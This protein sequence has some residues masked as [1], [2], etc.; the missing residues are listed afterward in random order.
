MRYAFQ[1]QFFKVL[2]NPTRI[3]VLDALRDGEH[4]VSDLCE[5]LDT[6]QTTMS[7]HLAVLRSNRFVI[8]ERDGATVRYSVSDPDIFTLLD[9]ATKIFKNK[10]AGA[11]TLL[12]DLRRGA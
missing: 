2:A 9:C 8:T 12:K 1:A 10:R 6:E 3:R 4:S 7:Q 5:R 11:R